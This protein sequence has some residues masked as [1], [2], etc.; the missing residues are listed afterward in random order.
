[1]SISKSS[2]LAAAAAALLVSAP[3]KADVIYDLTFTGGGSGVLDLTSSFS[4]QYGNTVNLNTSGDFVSLILTDVDGQN[5][6]ITSSNLGAGSSITTDGSDTKT[7]GKITN[8]DVVEAAPA[9][10]PNGTD[11]VIAFTQEA[12]VFSTP[13]GHSE[14][15]FEFTAS[16]PIIAAVPEPSTWALMILGFCTLGFVAYRRKQSGPSL[17]IA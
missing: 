8:L 3:A 12:T 15:R 17:R 5:F 2:L 16:A 13:N 6:T 4:N 11:Y 9:G 7:P 10:A 14:G 1:M